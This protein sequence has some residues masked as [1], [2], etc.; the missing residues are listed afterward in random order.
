MKKLQ[1][2][3]YVRNLTQAQWDLLLAIEDKS[4]WVRITRF[5]NNY[6]IYEYG[7][8]LPA[9][10]KLGE[11]LTFEEF[12]LRATR[13]FIT[14]KPELPQSKTF[15]YEDDCIHCVNG[16]VRMVEG[17]QEHYEE[18][19]QCDGKG[20]YSVQIDELSIFEFIQNE[21]KRGNQSAIN[22]ISKK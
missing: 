4:D 2:G 9:S 16:G 6:M 14:Q 10:A 21:V 18:C 3:D 8:L 5:E 13:T 20:N 17:D 7:I 1:K 19:D 15:L 12:K 11:E 22:L